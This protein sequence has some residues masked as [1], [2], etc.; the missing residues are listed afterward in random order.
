MGTSTATLVVANGDS[1]YIFR[2]M[3][4][5]RA[6]AITGEDG[7]PSKGLLH[8]TV[9]TSDT[10]G[11]D[12]NVSSLARH[13]FAPGLRQAMSLPWSTQVPMAASPQ[14]LLDKTV[15]FQTELV[16][17]AEVLMPSCTPMAATHYLASGL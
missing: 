16:W 11:S 5:A 12:L 3:M 1:A 2:N 10:S 9:L 13:T 17:G 14:P 15:D 6:Y 4:S 7:M 8:A